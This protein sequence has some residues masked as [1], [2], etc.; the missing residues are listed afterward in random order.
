MATTAMTL[1]SQRYGGD[2]CC[3]G[4]VTSVPL[5][6]AMGE[7]FTLPAG[8]GD[9]LVKFFEVELG[10]LSGSYVAPTPAYE[11][12][13]LKVTDPTT[14]SVDILGAFRFVHYSTSS[15]RP[16]LTISR[17]LN[18]PVLFRQTERIQIDAPILAGAGV[19]GN[20]VCRIV[21]LRLRAP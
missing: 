17:D 20:V 9:M 8:F 14:T 10:A 12:M 19:T 4:T 7:L 5:D 16:A 18:R 6:A 11:G 13:R 2:A 21:G 15:A 1:I 3:A